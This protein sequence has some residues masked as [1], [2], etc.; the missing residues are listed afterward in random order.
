MRG[1]DSHRY[2]A[3]DAPR[4]SP[5]LARERRRNHYGNAY[6]Y[7]ITP[8]CA[9]KTDKDMSELWQGKDHPRLRGKDVHF[10]PRSS[11]SLGSPPLARERLDYGNGQENQGRI[12]PACAGKTSDSPRTKKRSEDHPRL[13]GKDHE[14]LQSPDGNKGSPPLARERLFEKQGTVS[15]SGITPACAGKTHLLF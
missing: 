14:N 11:A 1:K 12:T 6:A 15:G 2:S 13:R 3:R 4:G 9:G 8:A 7:R 10:R 5:P